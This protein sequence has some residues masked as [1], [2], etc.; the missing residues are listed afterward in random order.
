MP[1]SRGVLWDKR[2]ASSRQPFSYVKVCRAAEVLLLFATMIVIGF[3]DV[4]A[5]RSSFVVVACLAGEI[6]I[7]MFFLER[8][9]WKRLPP[10]IRERIPYDSDEA[11]RSKGD[12]RSFGQLVRLLTKRSEWP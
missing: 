7:V 6:L 4:A 9:V 1:G 3:T 10:R 11:T 8:L 2:P 5:G 12:I